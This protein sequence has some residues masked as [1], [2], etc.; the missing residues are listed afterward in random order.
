MGGERY[1]SHGPFPSQHSSRR[2]LSSR[3]SRRL[4][5][6]SDPPATMLN[7][8]RCRWP[9]RGGGGLLMV[10]GKA[11]PKRSPVIGRHT[12]TATSGAHLPSLGCGVWGGQ[13]SAKF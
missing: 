3:L 11:V 7:Q 2:I 8:R 9:L 5:I 10:F 12:A 1:Q 13:N 4:R 6:L